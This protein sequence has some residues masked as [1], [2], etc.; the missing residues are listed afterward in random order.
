[1][2]E[3]MVLT[4]ATLESQLWGQKPTLILVSNGEGLRSDF[5]TAFKKALED[6]PTIG[7]AKLDPTTNPQAAARFDVGSK[8]VMIGWYNG[9][10]ILRRPRPWGTD[11]P[12]AVEMLQ[13]VAQEQTP[14]EQEIME[15]PVD[16]QPAVID[17]KPVIVT[18]A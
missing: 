14:V 6:H 12:L 5:S 18:D 7:F 9:A 16:N 10:E 4:D 3:L 15:K 17:G 13:K 1:M 11:V 2:A 8:P